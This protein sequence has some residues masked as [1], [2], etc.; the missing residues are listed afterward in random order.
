M[1]KKTD[2]TYKIARV[3][4]KTYLCRDVVDNGS[5]GVTL[6]SAANLDSVYEGDKVFEGKLDD[7]HWIGEFAIAYIEANKSNI[8]VHGVIEIRD[9]YNDILEDAIGHVF[10]HVEHLT[11]LN[12]LEEILKPAIRKL[13]KRN[14]DK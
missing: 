12:G 14:L 13:I 5:K 4:D 6:L 1:K 3:R 8:K 11:S 2:N 10:G 9:Y 7:P